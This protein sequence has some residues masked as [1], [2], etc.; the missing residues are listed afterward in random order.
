MS[1]AGARLDV[2]STTTGWEVRGDI[3][4]H[5]APTL[6]AAMSQLPTGVVTVDVGGV[7]FMDSSGLRV[8]LEAATRARDGGGDLIIV[9]STPGITRLVEISG[10]GEQLRLDD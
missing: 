1:D 5:T 6:A 9:H 7:S 8:L 3:D 4:A 10:L 2:R